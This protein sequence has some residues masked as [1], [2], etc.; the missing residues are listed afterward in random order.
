MCP[1]TNQWLLVVLVV[2]ALA[3]SNSSSSCSPKVL[4]PRV[5]NPSPHALLGDER[6]QLTSRLQRSGD[7]SALSIHPPRVRYFRIIDH[8]PHIL[9]NQRSWFTSGFR[10]SGVSTFSCSLSPERNLP[11]VN[12]IST[13]VSHE[14]MPSD[15]FGASR[16]GSLKYSPTQTFRMQ[17]S[18]SVRSSNKCLLL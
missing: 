4:S 7:P 16:F 18:H 12:D 8:A 11:G 13:H 2:Q 15:H 17:S 10:C 9:P 5:N 14:S 6:S 3:I 1:P